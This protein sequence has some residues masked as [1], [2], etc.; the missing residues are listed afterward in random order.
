MFVFEKYHVMFQK[1]LWRHL[2]HGLMVSL[3][4][5]YCGRTIRP[6]TFWALL[7]GRNL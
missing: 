5:T 2:N 7:M 6:K 3:N 1:S 4:Y